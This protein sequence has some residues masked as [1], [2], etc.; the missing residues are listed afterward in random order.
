MLWAGEEEEQECDEAVEEEDFET[1]GVAEPGGGVEFEE[2]A[3]HRREHCDEGHPTVVDLALGEESEGV[4]T[5]QRT[6]GE[7]CNVEDGVDERLV[8]ERSE[9]DDYQQVEQGKTHMD[10]PTDGHR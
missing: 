9:S 5:Q 3:E 1:E 6:V 2:I 8:V 7:A 10:H 4:E